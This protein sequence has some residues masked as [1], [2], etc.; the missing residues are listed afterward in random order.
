MELLYI[1]TGYWRCLNYSYYS[2]KC[3]KWEWVEE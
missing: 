1:L 2:G 3:L